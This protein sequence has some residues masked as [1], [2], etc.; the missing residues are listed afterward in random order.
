[1]DE[2]VPRARLTNLFFSSYA[3][4]DIMRLAVQNFWAKTSVPNH[5][6]VKITKQL[7]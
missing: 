5:D 2:T 1:M 7:M 3:S 6:D 4:W